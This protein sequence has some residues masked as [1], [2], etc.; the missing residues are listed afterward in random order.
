MPP[1]ER[2]R[3]RIKDAPEDFVVEELPL[4]ELEG[5]GDHLFVRFTKREL[6]TDD[7]VRA[8]ARAAGV[9]ARDIGVAGLKDKVGI[10]TQTVSLPVPRAENATFDAKV[11]ALEIPGVVIHEAKRH[12]NKLKTGHLNG[13]RFK[14]AVR[15]IL[16]ADVEQVILALERAGREGI[17]NAFGSQRFGREKNNAAQ[18]FAWLT[19]TSKGPRDPR[20]KRFL[21]SALQSELFNA[22]LDRRVAEGTW[23]TPLVGDVLKKTDT[24]GLF[25]CGDEAIDQERAERGLVSPTGPM[26][27]TKMREATGRPGE[28]ERQIFDQRLGA[29]FDLA[30]TKPFGEG[31]RRSLCLGIDAMAV[32]RIV[33]RSTEKDGAFEEQGASLW[34]SFV[35]PKGAYATSVLATAVDFETN[36]PTQQPAYPPTD[37]S[38]QDL[39]RSTERAE[40]ELE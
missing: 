23:R 25:E 24:G 40:T 37:S 13:N 6:T 38:L 39:E 35:L 34:V 26:F 30:Q 7:V 11:L 5:T 15:G 17:P 1:A 19:G 4:Y 33:K 9:Q 12:V 36:Q 27:G 10:T 22:V 2:P 29:G 21:W 3:A 14:V 16:E 18:A 28:L 32:E 20:Q 31:T 8:L